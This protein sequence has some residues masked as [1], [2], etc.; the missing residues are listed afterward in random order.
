MTMSNKKFTKTTVMEICSSWL[1]DDDWL[2]IKKIHKM[3]PT[4]DSSALIPNAQ[5]VELIFSSSILSIPLDASSLLPFIQ[6]RK[7]KMR[8]TDCSEQMTKELTEFGKMRR[9]RAFPPNLETKERGIIQW[10]SL[11]KWQRRRKRDKK[12]Q[13]GEKRRKREGETERSR[14]FGSVT[15]MCH[16]LAQWH[17]TQSNCPLSGL[18]ISLASRD[19]V[20]LPQ[21][22][23]HTHI[24][25]DCFVHRSIK[26][27]F[28][29]SPFASSKIPLVSLL[30]HLRRRLLHAKFLSWFSCQ[31]V[32]F[33]YFQLA[34][35]RKGSQR[36][37]EYTEIYKESFWNWGLMGTY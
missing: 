7:S 23:A 2:K 34:L 32:F 20:S 33:F 26:G 18:C 13:R 37:T 30:L 11:S 31:R 35:D 16:P 14:D 29:K 6:V 25:N 19:L 8:E 27:L 36:R 1:C 21:L 12:G 17:R 3:A 10:V 28:I 9:L 15:V 5:H 24:I 22:N 4:R